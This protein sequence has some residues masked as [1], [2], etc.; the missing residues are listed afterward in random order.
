[1]RKIIHNHHTNNAK[2]N[3]NKHTKQTE[4]HHHKTIQHHTP[5]PSQQKLKTQQPSRKDTTIAH[6]PPSTLI[7]PTKQLKYSG[8][9]AIIR[10]FTL[11][12]GSSPLATLKFVFHLQM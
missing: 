2:H 4:P 7:L 12:L 3:R 11:D 1:M 6:L 5:F 9:R 8:E 10:V